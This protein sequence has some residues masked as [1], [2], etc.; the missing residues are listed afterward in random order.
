MLINAVGC[1]DYDHELAQTNNLRAVS[2]ACQLY[3]TSYGQY[4]DNLRDSDLAPLLDGDFAPLDDE[5]GN[6]LRYQGSDIGFTLT[7]LGPDGQLGT[8]DDIQLTHPEP[9]E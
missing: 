5:W 4:P 8:K 7:S 1:K 9:E 2:I 6:P 3:H